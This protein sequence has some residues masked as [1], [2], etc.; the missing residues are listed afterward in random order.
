MTSAAP[1]LSIVATA[2][3]LGASTASLLQ[4]RQMLRSGTSK[5][6]SIGFLAS[7]V[8]GYAIW[9][10]YGISI[11]SAPLMVVDAV[12]ALSGG[13]TLVVA[14]RARSG[15][16]GAAASA[17]SGSFSRADSGSPVGALRVPAPADPGDLLGPSETR[18]DEGA[19]GEP[20]PVAPTP[21]VVSG[22]VP[23]PEDV[24]GVAASPARPR[25]GSEVSPRPK[26]ACAG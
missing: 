23:T 26:A 4:A 10:L 7:F 14:I 15:P 6:V 19:H 11:G 17:P 1:V 18:R 3:G 21:E 24:R 9:L 20:G 8:G 5:D 25:A 16:G 2:Y 22:L 13:F 12:G